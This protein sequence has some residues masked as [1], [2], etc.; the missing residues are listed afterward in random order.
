MIIKRFITTLLASLTIAAASASTPTVRAELTP[1]SIGIGDRFTYS[2]IVERDMMQE[3][4]FPIFDNKKGNPI[5]MLE[6]IPI[7]TIARDGRKL[8]LKKS[9]RLISFEEGEHNLGPAR[10]IYLDKNI[11]DTLSSADST[12]V[13]INTFEI[14]TTKQSIMALKPQLDMRFKKEEVMGYVTWSLA[15]AL[16]LAL[17]IFILH[18]YLKSRG[19]RIKDIFK[20]APLPA[21]HIEAI[22]ALELLHNQKLWQAEKYKE[23]Y[24]QLTHIARHY[25]SRRYGIAAMEMTS[26]QIIKATAKIDIPTKSRMDLTQVLHTAD[27]TK[28]AKQTIEGEENEANYLKIYYFVEETKV[29]EEQTSRTEGEILRDKISNKSK[30]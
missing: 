22:R 20:P 17:L 9:Y 26:A 13:R 29:Q 10:V 11:R 2:I 19:K 7:D 15:G 24:S 3:T 28:F 21:P 5:E 25:I 4:S 18:R 6:D 1:D 23:Y 16:L 8:T 12:L 27:L 30:N 14:D